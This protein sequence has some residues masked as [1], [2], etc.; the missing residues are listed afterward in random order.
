MM[1][2]VVKYD[3]VDGATELREVPI[4]EIGP[5]DVLVKVAYI[6]I[7]GS[8]PH[9]H[10]NKV[11][12]KVNVPLI[13]GHEFSGTIEKIGENVQGYKVGD[14]VTAETHADYCGECILCRTNNYH[15][16][17]ER[18][19]YGFHTDGAFAKYVK[20]PSR[21]L[22][23]VPDNV[24]LK[25][26]SLTEPLCVA[27]S[28]LVK[29]SKIKPGDLVVIIG[30][31]PIGLLCTKIAS[32]VGASDIIVIGT[33][34]DEGRLELAKKLGATVTINSSK[35]DPIPVIKGMRDGYG[36]DLVVD[37]AGFSPTFKLAVDVV[38]PCGEINKIGWGPKPVDF[39]LDPLI[40]KAVTVNFTFSHNWDVW[41]QCLVLMSQKAVDLNDFITHEL[42]LD[43]WH[44]GFELI[45]SKEGLKIV[46]TPID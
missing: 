6:G 14:R 32:I 7:C 30:P 36:A 23:R 19:G 8:D 28:S 1:K 18:K 9:M 45:E 25:E 33:D 3:N 26:A 16:C 40:T 46:L 21:I 41:E 5:N 43:K 10:H 4:P 13:L 22:H 39:S 38:K 44:E 20:V 12:Y 2:A 27:Y 29:H 17:R 35:E 15:V 31:G 37:T 34:G 42:P 11:T 24:S